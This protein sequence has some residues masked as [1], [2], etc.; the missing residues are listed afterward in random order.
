MLE[1]QNQ[2]LVDSV[3]KLISTDELISVMMN[4]SIDANKKLELLILM[5]AGLKETCQIR[6]INYIKK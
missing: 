2:I 4:K 5:A 6:T 3:F 1:P